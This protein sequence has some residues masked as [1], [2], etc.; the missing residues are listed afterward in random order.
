METH[1][2]QDASDSIKPPVT[3]VGVIGWLRNNLFNGYLNSFLT[4]VTLYLLWLTVPPFFKWAFIDSLWF[5]SAEECRTTDGACWSI[6][7]HNIRFIIFGFY[8]HDQQW[9]PLTAMI[10]L[11]GLL[12]FSQNRVHWKKSLGYYW[13]ISYNNILFAWAPIWPFGR[14]YCLFWL[15]IFTI[16]LRSLV[17]R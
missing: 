14:S 1:Q 13:I 11:V 8:P 6:I 2:P 15:F 4:L 12:F 9:R 5:S 10:L 3:S 16:W 7:P 17:C